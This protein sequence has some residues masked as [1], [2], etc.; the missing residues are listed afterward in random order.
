M[1]SI[2]DNLPQ[3]I[4]SLVVKQGQV[5][6]DPPLEDVRSAHYRTHLRPLLTIPMNFKVSIA[7]LGGLSATLVHLQHMRPASTIACGC[8]TCSAVP[9]L[10]VLELVL[11]VCNHM[12]GVSEASERPGFFKRIMEAN[13]AGIAKAYAATEALFAQLQVGSKGSL[14]GLLRAISFCYHLCEPK[15]WLLLDLRCFQIALSDLCYNPTG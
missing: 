14:S 2:N 15:T 7:Y 1:E 13:A 11:L 10:R 6:Y 12:Q 5:T 3:V 8:L 4:V 9:R